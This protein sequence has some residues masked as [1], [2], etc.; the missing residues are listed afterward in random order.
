[1]GSGK[2]RIHKRAGGYPYS[3]YLLTRNNRITAIAP[4]RGF[5]KVCPL[6]NTHVNQCR[7]HL[8]LDIRLL[9]SEE[10]KSLWPM[11]MVLYAALTMVLHLELTATPIVLLPF[12]FPKEEIVP[13]SIQSWSNST[14]KLSS[15]LSLV[16][17]DYLLLQLSFRTA[18]SAIVQVTD[19]TNDETTRW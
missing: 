13:I 17:Q 15:W 18:L 1:M 12:I 14:H 11:T 8:Q 5:F 9:R 10:R 19:G 4:S 2:R 3:C 6:I 16:W 7:T